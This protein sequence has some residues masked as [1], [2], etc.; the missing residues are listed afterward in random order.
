LA[1]RYNVLQR[2]LRNVFSHDDGIVEVDSDDKIIPE[3]NRLIEAGRRVIVLDVDGMATQDLTEEALAAKIAGEAGKDYC[4]I[5]SDAEKMKTLD[6]MTVAFVNLHAMTMMG[7]GILTDDRG[8]F[9]TAHMAF[10]G[11]SDIKDLIDETTSKIKWLVKRLPRTVPYDITKQDEMNR[12][13]ALFRV[14]A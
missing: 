13:N 12:L 11:N 2:Q 5:A 3:T 6:N 4:F 1:A 9:E 10:T 8:L 7:L 14:A